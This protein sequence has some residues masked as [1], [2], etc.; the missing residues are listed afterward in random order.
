MGFFLE[1]T[2]AEVDQGAIIQQLLLK[3]LL[4]IVLGLLLNPLLKKWVDK[5]SKWIGQFD[6][7]IILLIVYE[8]FSDAFVKQ[9]FLSVSFSLFP[10]N[11]GYSFQCE[12]G[13]LEVPSV[14]FANHGSVKRALVDIKDISYNSTC[15]NTY[16]HEDQVNKDVQQY[17]ETKKPTNFSNHQEEDLDFIDIS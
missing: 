16:Y 8:S 12:G 1:N 2:S 4:P 17:Q 3:V 5:Y 13:S 15:Q 14:Y 10:S 7:F 11:E 6:R 9:I